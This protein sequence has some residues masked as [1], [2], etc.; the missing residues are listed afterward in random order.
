MIAA[1]ADVDEFDVAAD[2]GVDGVDDVTDVD[3]TDDVAD[4]EPVPV[5]SVPDVELEQAASSDAAATAVII[6]LRVGIFTA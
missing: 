6:T 4:G 2:D 5:E 3:V 1:A